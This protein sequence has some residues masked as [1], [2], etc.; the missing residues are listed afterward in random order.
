MVDFRRVWECLIEL[1]F[2][3]KNGKGFKIKVELVWFW[4]IEKNFLFNNK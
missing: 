2:V 4:L 1:G 3:E